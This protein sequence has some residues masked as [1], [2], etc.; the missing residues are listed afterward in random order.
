MVG[1]QPKARL[2]IKP[3]N[4]KELTR[5]MEIAMDLEET[6]N[7]DKGGV[8]SYQNSQYR[9]TIARGGT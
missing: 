6:P 5:A 7:W 4:P 1:L 9:F 2:L 8:S 3:L